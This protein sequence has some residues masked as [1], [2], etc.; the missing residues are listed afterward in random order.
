MKKKSDRIAELEK[1]VAQLR[2]EMMEIKRI[3]QGDITSPSPSTSPSPCQTCPYKDGPKDM[4]GRLGL[5][6]SPCQF[7]PHYKWR[8]TYLQGAKQE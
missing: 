1:E 2:R 4:M 8:I 6:D 7:C 3:A 5:G